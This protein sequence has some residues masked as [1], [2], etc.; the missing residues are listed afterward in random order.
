MPNCPFFIANVTLEDD[1]ED[2]IVVANLVPT[3]PP[4]SKASTSRSGRTHTR[5]AS[6]SNRIAATASASEIEPDGDGEDD[7][8]AL[9]PSRQ[10]LPRTASAKAATPAPV[11]PPRVIPKSTSS[12]RLKTQHGDLEMAVDN[13]DEPP[14]STVSKLSSKTKKGKAKTPQ[15]EPSDLDV[16]E[17]AATSTKSSKRAKGKQ[18][19]IEEVQVIDLDDD[20]VIEEPPPSKKSATKSSKS[21]SKSKR[22]K[23]KATIVAQEDE[24][25]AAPETSIEPTDV[26]MEERKLEVQFIKA[27]P[28]PVARPPPPKLPQVVPVVIPKLALQSSSRTSRPSNDEDVDL[29]AAEEELENM[30]MELDPTGEVLKSKTSSSRPA[31]SRSGL[32]PQN[33]SS[34]STQ[35]RGKES[36]LQAASLA[37]LKT[38]PKPMSRAGSVR[39]MMMEDEVEEEEVARS[40]NEMEEEGEV[41]IDTITK[42]RPPSR[43][44]ERP[45]FAVPPPQ[46]NGQSKTLVERPTVSSTSSKGKTKAKSEVA[47]PEPRTPPPAAITNT[48]APLGEVD[49][50]PSLV[51][52]NKLLPDKAQIHHL[53]EEEKDMTLEAYI[54]LQ[55]ERRKE[56][57]RADGERW[58]EDFLAYAE[59][60]RGTIRAM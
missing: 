31:S 40:L 9:A 39:A 59:Q 12:R 38:G 35:H 55:I 41:D 57:L 47:V 36:A 53:T 3:Q 34:S 30:A 20:E 27:P 28:H 49:S 37:W 25:E 13:N 7:T 23:T 32:K 16:Q 14:Q 17:V 6:K 21:S 29:K 1:Q 26:E 54:R 51:L 22:G 8:D 56:V 15:T 4:P 48:L 10:T 33:A 5:T 60:V 24:P 18:K 2:E 45:P 19:A 11:D 44:A 58:I 46:T 42:L 43:N 52:P 50:A